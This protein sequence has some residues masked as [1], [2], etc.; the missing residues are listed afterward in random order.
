MTECRGESQLHQLA[1]GIFQ[2]AA[3]LLLVVQ[4]SLTCLEM[5][6]QKPGR[7]GARRRLPS[8]SPAPTAD[9]ADAEG[10]GAVGLARLQVSTPHCGRA[11]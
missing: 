1:R 9:A 2:S 11:P 10:R 7:R 6:R 8:P 5:D 3:A 4:L